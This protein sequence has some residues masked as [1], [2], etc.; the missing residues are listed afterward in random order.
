MGMVT[1]LAVVGSLTS[2]TPVT[3]LSLLPEPTGPRPAG[4]EGT[5]NCGNYQL[6]DFVRL[7][8]R[9]SDIIL[10]IVGSLALLM[11]VYGGFTWILSGGSSDKVQQ[12]KDILRNAV[13]GL[14]LVFTSWLIVSVV[15]RAFVC[16][17]E[18]PCT[19]NIFDRPWSE[20]PPDDLPTGN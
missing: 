12:G 11:F 4:C 10:G 8:V 15:V 5:D 17:P 7:A 14:I 20:A 9:V 18:E 3:A 13:I 1:I 2:Y 16:T 6:S 19:G